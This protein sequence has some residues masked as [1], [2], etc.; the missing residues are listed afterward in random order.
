MGVCGVTDYQFVRGENAALLEG[1]LVRLEKLTRV[2]QLRFGQAGEAGSN[3]YGV[4]LSNIVQ[5]IA[6]VRKNCHR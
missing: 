3:L 1:P 4:G 6:G 5:R 2:V